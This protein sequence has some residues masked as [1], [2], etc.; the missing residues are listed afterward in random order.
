MRL[1][2]IRVKAAKKIDG[3]QVFAPTILVGNPF[4]LFSGVVQ[5]E[6]G[7]DGIHA[8]SVHMINIHPHQS[9]AHQEAAHLI[10]PIVED[11]ASPVR[12]KAL[13][14]ISV[15]KKVSAI[16][17]GKPVLICWEVRW[18]PVEINPD[19]M[20]MQVVDQVHEILRGSVSAGGCKVSS[21]LVTP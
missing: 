8:Q 1:I 9:A 16:K 21:G 2:Q 17:V 19:S 13:P 20:L 3:I 15:L 18:D 5:I 12:M 14:G 6:H 10:A 4:T 7:R 11:V